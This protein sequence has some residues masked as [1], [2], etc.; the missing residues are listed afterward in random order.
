MIA[1]G[2]ATTL[3]GRP[4]LLVFSDDDTPDLRHLLAVGLV[5]Q[6]PG[7]LTVMGRGPRD[8]AE[9]ILGGFWALA[10]RGAVSD[11]DRSAIAAALAAPESPAPRVVMADAGLSLVATLGP[12]VSARAQVAGWHGGTVALSGELPAGAP[13]LA[14]ARDWERGLP[15]AVAD[16]TL[17]VTGMGEP[18]EITLD[19][20]TTSLRSAAREL[21]VSSLE[22]HTTTRR[23]AAATLTIRRRQHLRLSE[24]GT[25]VWAGFDRDP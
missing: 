6:G 17:T 15:A 25:V 20:S 5:V 4:D 9:G 3:P 1:L 21:H 22:R 19:E 7:S 2:T 14:L 16:L 13:G 10:L 12:D 24:H 8:R 23:T 11:A 18:A